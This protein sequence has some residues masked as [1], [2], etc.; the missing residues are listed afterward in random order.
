MKLSK[1]IIALALALTALD[2]I[3]EPGLLEKIKEDHARAV[4][5]QDE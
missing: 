2:L 5:S 4:A 3:T 1:K